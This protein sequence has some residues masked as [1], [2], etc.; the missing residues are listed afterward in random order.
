MKLEFL[1]CPSSISLG[2]SRIS[3]LIQAH[4]LDFLEIACWYWPGL[5]IIQANKPGMC[6]IKLNFR[7][8]RAFQ[9]N[10][11]LSDSLKIQVK[12]LAISFIFHVVRHTS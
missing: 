10:S 6:R 9:E 7:Q 2:Y 1:E 8:E 3:N 12:C 4:F 11:S 5:A